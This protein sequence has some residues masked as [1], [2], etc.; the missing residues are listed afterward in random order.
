VIT[1]VV[2]AFYR[3]KSSYIRSL[4]ND[5]ENSREG[6]PGPIRDLVN[7]EGPMSSSKNNKSV[8][9]GKSTTSPGKGKEAE[10]TTKLLEIGG[11]ENLVDLGNE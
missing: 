3:P 1:D 2:L 6:A 8:D 7:R 4:D 11:P 9:F 10:S 5:F